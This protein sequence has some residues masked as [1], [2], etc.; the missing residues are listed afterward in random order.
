MGEE[1]RGSRSTNSHGDVMYSIK[2]GVTKELIHMTHGYEQW[3]GDCL[4]E[5]VVLGGEGQRG[6]IWD[7]CNSIINKYIFFKKRKSK[8]LQ[9]KLLYPAKLSFKIK[10]QILSFPDKKK[11]NEASLPKQYYINC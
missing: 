10:G 3:C 9:P 2:N 5:R 6:K 4:R 7:N 8:D 1:V 11:P